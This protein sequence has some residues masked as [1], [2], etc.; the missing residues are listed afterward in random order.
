MASSA[1]AASTAAPSAQQHHPATALLSPP[2][3]LAVA[4]LS[5]RAIHGPLLHGGHGGAG[6]WLAPE[7]APGSPLLGPPAPGYSLISAALVDEA[8]CSD[9]GGPFLEYILAFHVRQAPVPGLD[10]TALHWKWRAGHRYSEFSKLDAQLRE[11]EEDDGGSSGDEKPSGAGGRGRGSI[12]DEGG[13]PAA[14]SHRRAAAFAAAS[15]TGSYSMASVPP[16]P[17]L[18]PKAGM[19]GML[20][21]PS[22]PFLAHRRMELALYVRDGIAPRLQVALSAHTAFMA[23]SSGVNNARAASSGSGPLD[24]ALARFCRVPQLRGPSCTPVLASVARMV[25]G[26]APYS[27]GEAAALAAAFAAHAAA[28]ATQSGGA[29]K[30]SVPQL[31]LTTTTGGGGSGGVAY[32]SV[33]VAA[34]RS[35]ATAVLKE[36]DP[37]AAAALLPASARSP[38]GGGGV[39]A[40]ASPST[41]LPTSS[42]SVTGGSLVWVDPSGLVARV[43]YAV[44]AGA[45]ADGPGLTGVLVGADGIT[46]FSTV[47]RRHLDSVAV[48]CAASAALVALAA[49]ASPPHTAMAANGGAADGVSTHS[50][51]SQLVSRPDQNTSARDLAFRCGLIGVLAS[52]LEVHGA[53]RRAARDV[54]AALAG[55]ALGREV[56]VCILFGH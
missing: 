6:G 22:I 39:P 43:F 11:G 49:C 51:S 4:Q 41:K 50:A 30:G 27:S 31:A 32:A 48:V 55:E 44:R 53:S 33:L 12:D 45:L 42:A 8:Q 9:A 25:T 15:I 16:L 29:Q 52:A 20:T 18:P 56:T 47:L 3:R 14:A 21:G 7:T 13:A 24:A 37:L 36:G 23:I 40:G 38:G 54:C 17:E 28:T 46:A 1:A 10:G 35:L 2:H 26:G 34:L 19:W 5:G